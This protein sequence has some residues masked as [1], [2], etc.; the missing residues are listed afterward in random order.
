MKGF[1]NLMTTVSVL[2]APISFIMFLRADKDT[3]ESLVNARFVSPGP[4][5]YQERSLF[6]PKNRIVTG[7]LIGPK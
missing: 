6:A 2:L 1:G 5:Y 3:L 7:S 4:T